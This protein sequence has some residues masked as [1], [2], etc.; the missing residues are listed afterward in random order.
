MKNLTLTPDEKA[1]R[2]TS[3]RSCRTSRP[4]SAS[5]GSWPGAAAHDPLTDPPNRALLADRLT[6]ALT[7]AG[8]HPRGRRRC[9]SSPSTTS[10]SSTTASDADAALLAATSRGPARHAFFD[11]ALRGR[12]R[13]RLEAVD[14]L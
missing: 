10:S 5:R 1:R 13:E 6:P 14:E 7:G 3:R 12:G 9:C 2:P 11:A 4:A 8:A